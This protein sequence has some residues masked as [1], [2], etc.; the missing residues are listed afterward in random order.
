MINQNKLQRFTDLVAVQ[1]ELVYINEGYTD[2]VHK[3]DYQVKIKPGRKYTKVDVG[4]SGK[5]MIDND[6][7][8]I[9]GI[10][11]YGVV[12]KGHCYGTLDTI[13]EWTWGEFRPRKRR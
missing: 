13:N 9:Y 4:R 12:H 11:A 6:T 5:F 3:P 10:K 7:E 8:T 1:T 2:D